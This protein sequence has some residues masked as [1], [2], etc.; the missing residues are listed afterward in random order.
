MFKTIK[1]IFFTLLAFYTLF[2]FFI[3]P[4]VLKPLIINAVQEKTNATIEIEKIYFNPFIFKLEIT[5]IKLTS[6]ENKELV[7][8]KE[9]L[10]NVE[11][12]SLFRTALH[13]KDFVL[14]E[15]KISLVYNADKTFNFS[16]LLKEN[17][18]TQEDDNTSTA[19][20]RIILE[21]IKIVNGFVAYEDFTQKTKFDFSFGNIGLELKDVDTKDLNASDASFRF[22]SLLGDGGFVDFKSKIVSLE[23]FISRGSLDFEASKLYT[24]YRYIQDML[25]LEVADGKISAHANFFINLDD[26][27]ATTIDDASVLLDNLR[28]KPKNKNKDILNLGSLYI[29]GITVKPM[30]QDAHIKNITLNS[31]VA[32][33]ARDAQGNI[34]WL[35]YIQVQRTD[36][37][38]DTD[39]NKTLEES[40]PWKVLID[41]LALEKIKADFSDKGISPQ[42]NTKLNEL[43]LYAQNISLAGEE[44]FTYNL[45]MKLNDAFECFSKGEIKHDVLELNAAFNCKGFDIVHYR[46]YIDEAAKKELAVYNVKLMKA[47]LGFDGNVQLKQ[48]GEQTFINVNEANLSLSNFALNKRN[49]N[50]RLVDFQS[51][52]VSGLTLDFQ[53]KNLDINKTM[54]KNFQLKTKMFANGSLNLEGL[55]EPKKS[56]T[57]TK[58]ATK[59]KTQKEGEFRVKLKHFGVE[60]AAVNFEDATLSPSVTTKIDRIFVNLYDIDSQAQSWLK[61]RLYLRVNSKGIARANGSLRHTPLKQNGTFDLSDLS[62]KEFTP[63][64]GQGAYLKIEDGA[65]DA[66]TKTRYESGSKKADVEVDGVIKLKEFF[67]ADSRDN[68]SLLSLHSLELKGFELDLLPNRLYI[69]EA[70]IDSFYVDAVIDE[71]KVMNFASLTKEDT[72]ESKKEVKE[73][74]TKVSPEDEKTVF[75]YRVEKLNLLSGSA[76]FAD[77]SL[78][79][80]FQTNIHD[81]SG[82]VLAISSVAGDV[83][84]VDVIGEV[85]AYGSSKLKG[86]LDS[87]NP[88]KFT[89]LGLSFK[90]LELNSMSGYSASFAGY[91]I[92]SGKLYLD[93]GY[94]IKDSELL[95]SNSIII[96]KI[97]LGEEIKDENTSSLP[98][99]F[100]I[101]LLE[102]NE[103]V[104]DIDMPVEG[105]VDAPDFKY[106]AL[107]LKTLGN[108]I[109]KAVASPFKFLGAVM[110]IDSE[111]LEYVSFEPGKAEILPP[112]R[113]KLDQIITILTKRPKMLLSLSGVYDVQSDK[114][115]LGLEKL[116]ALAIKESGAKSKEEQ[117]N[118]MNIDILEDIYDDLKDDDKLDDIKDALKEKYEGDEFKREYFKALVREN[119]LLQ[120]VSKEELEALAALR[121]KNIRIYLMKEHKLEAQ[122]ILNAEIKAIDVPENKSV[123]MNLAVEVK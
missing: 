91:A 2:G 85:D 18:Q 44:P 73:S 95:G 45:N 75:P 30:L 86:S 87:A 26:L 5:G 117:Q 42:V 33:V 89:D 28:I 66:H 118:A 8:L 70:N 102:D 106:G 97:K 22:Y 15:P 56:S 46:P 114:K 116:I 40:K 1:K 77:L 39:A 111:K 36:T 65:L 41:A 81:V 55:V 48:S 78:P 68:N 17:N 113:E 71:N 51:F 96:K 23:P 115:A 32:K 88:K 3:L 100:V 112:Q 38:E 90:N 74:K 108:L 52:D 76:K 72:H 69:G 99:G 58:K 24:E 67:L 79:I 37:H 61:Y 101:A 10:A 49:T 60:A 54:L 29:D 98:L 63:Y 122:R 16:S 50:E 123:R 7:S 103:G 59:Q 20:P 84:Y 80:K 4:L 109:L 14:D 11:V 47:K 53:N 6:N 94:K 92:D 9:I 82:S 62:L 110:G 35:E 31:L 105:N 83:S 43:N 107:V 25:Q 27:N 19:L 93:L 57:G 13:V 34:D 64:I 104:I 119:I 121:A 120:A 12:Y 21:N